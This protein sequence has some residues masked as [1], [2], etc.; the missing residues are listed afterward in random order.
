MTTSL[1]FGSNFD[2]ASELAIT[3][4]S[5]ITSGG[6]CIADP[7]VT[8]STA[9]PGTM[10]INT[11][12]TPTDA[13]TGVVGTDPCGYLVYYSWSGTTAFVTFDAYSGFVQPVVSL[14]DCLKL[15]TTANGNVAIQKKVP[16][17]YKHSD[18]VTL[19]VGSTSTADYS[20][21]H[22]FIKTFETTSNVLSVTGSDSITDLTMTY[23]K[24]KKAKK[25]K[26]VVC[27]AP[28]SFTVSN[29]AITSGK[30]YKPTKTTCGYY[31]IYKWT[32]VDGGITFLINSN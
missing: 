21:Y 15:T 14:G 9:N 19:G 25:G 30:V 24:G 2:S 6:A 7:S 20:C 13:G 32:G 11:I 17:G 31:V 27:K 8:I 12:Y 26:K 29:G 3:Y 28:T 10:T 1:A 5:G 4:F 22:F 23:Y 16:K 18:L